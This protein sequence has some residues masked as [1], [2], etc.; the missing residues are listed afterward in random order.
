[1]NNEEP[2]F[3]IA[4]LFGKELTVGD[5][6]AYSTSCTSTGYLRRGVIYK[7]ELR[8]RNQSVIKF[9]SIT[10]DKEISYPFETLNGKKIYDYTKRIETLIPI[11]G[12]TSRRIY[13]DK[14]N[15]LDVIKLGS[16]LE[17]AFLEEEIKVINTKPGLKTNYK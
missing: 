4:D 17:E 2:F 16:C 9:K 13:V 15:K 3:Y 1:M 5:Y 8:S 10:I 12:V 11:I 7:I 6:I 14:K